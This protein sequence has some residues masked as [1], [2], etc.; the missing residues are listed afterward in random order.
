M[1]KNH[2]NTTVIVLTWIVMG[3]VSFVTTKIVLIFREY[4]KD[5]QLKRRLKEIDNKYRW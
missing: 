4:I 1:E 2:M 5:R 3:I